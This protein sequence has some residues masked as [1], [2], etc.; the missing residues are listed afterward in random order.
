M[1]KTCKLQTCNELHTVELQDV[2]FSPDSKTIKRV[3]GETILTLPIELDKISERLGYLENLL[4]NIT[5]ENVYK[6]IENELNNI[7]DLINAIEKDFQDIKG[8][9]TNIKSSLENI[10]SNAL[11]YSTF[12]DFIQNFENWKNSVKS[13]LNIHSVDINTL[14]TK[15]DNISDTLDNKL[16]NLDLNDL[17]SQIKSNNTKIENLDAEV[18]QVKKDLENLDESLEDISNNIFK[19]ELEVEEVLFKNKNGKTVIKFNSSVN[20]GSDYG[21]IEYDDDNNA[22]NYWG[23]SNENSALIIGVENDGKNTVSDVV[24]LKSPASVIVDSKDLIFKDISSGNRFSILDKLGL[25]IPDFNSG[26]LTVTQSGLTIN[27]PLGQNAFFIGYIKFNNNDIMQFGVY[28][29]YE[30]DD[31]VDG[32]DTGVYLVIQP[33]NLIISVRKRSN[34]GTPSAVG[35]GDGISYSTNIQNTFQAKIIGWKLPN[36]VV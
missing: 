35:L 3:S 20:Y 8:D 19:S 6:E 12:N 25:G 5:D 10:Q 15:V 9:F 16:G 28:S 36:G 24:V 18:N 4:H 13:Q 33:T 31:Y 30:D 1:I 2:L 17:D 14:K 21:Y 27:N 26:W 34:N 22:Y 29:G 11:S 32:Q 23:D 7:R